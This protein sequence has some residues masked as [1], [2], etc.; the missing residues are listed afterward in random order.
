MNYFSDVYEGTRSARAADLPGI[1]RV[2]QPLE[3]SGALIR[4]TNEEVYCVFSFSSIIVML[5][6]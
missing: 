1:R 3:E 6:S 4:R 5:N 2:I